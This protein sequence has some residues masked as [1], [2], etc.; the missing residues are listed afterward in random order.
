MGIPLTR[1]VDA[2]K[3]F[4][5]RPCYLTDQWMELRVGDPYHLDLHT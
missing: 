2:W 1:L 4:R 5:S 3:Q